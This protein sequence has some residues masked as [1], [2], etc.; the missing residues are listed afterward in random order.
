MPNFFQ[1]L[2][3]CSQAKVSFYTGDFTHAGSP[4]QCT[5]LQH[6]GNGSSHGRLPS[7]RQPRPVHF[8]STPLPRFLTRATSLTQAAPTSALCF[9]TSAT[10]PHKGD[11]PHAGSPDQCTLLQHL[12]NGFSQRVSEV[13]SKKALYLWEI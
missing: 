13:E 8:A 4:D 9:N 1:Q 6:L 12:G 5:L 11:F 2:G 3:R 10:V 7:R